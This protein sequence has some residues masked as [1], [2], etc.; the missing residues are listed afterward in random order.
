MIPVASKIPLTR[1]PVSSRRR[2]IAKTLTW[3]FF[4]ELDTFAVSYLITGSVTWAVSIVSIEAT[5]KTILY[6]LHERAWGHV[7]SGVPLLETS[8]DN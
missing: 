6:Y 7:A 5:T 1:K 8:R 2:S 4:A 3:R